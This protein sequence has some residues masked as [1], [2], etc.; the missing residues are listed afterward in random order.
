[1]FPRPFGLAD[2]QARSFVRNAR[3]RLLTWA[4]SPP[5]GEPHFVNERTVALHA[6]SLGSLAR[7]S[8]ERGVATVGALQPLLPVDTKPLSPEEEQ[9]VLSEMGDWTPG[10]WAE[11]A[12]QMYPRMRQEAK[13]AVEREGGTFLDMSGAFHAEREATYA[14]DVAHYTGL[15]NRRLAEALLPTVT[16]LLRERTVQK[17]RRV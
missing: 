14:Y 11:A 17:P 6:A 13:A 15:G 7:Y 12:R 16:S 4:G 10:P 5:V 1:M 9:A 2:H 3:I 8:R